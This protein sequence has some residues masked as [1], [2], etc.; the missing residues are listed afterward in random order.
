[1]SIPIPLEK[2]KSGCPDCGLAMREIDPHF[3][4]CDGCSKTAFVSDPAPYVLEVKTREREKSHVCQNC[5]V[6]F[7]SSRYDTKFCSSKCRVAYHRNDRKKPAFLLRDKPFSLEKFYL[8]DHLSPHSGN[9]IANILKHQGIDLGLQVMGGV[10]AGMCAVAPEI[11]RPFQ[12]IS[13]RE[14]DERMYAK[15]EAGQIA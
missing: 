5:D 1:M 4:I 14:F 15:R 2:I 3:Y 10:I 13:Q 8:V 9:M 7:T 12:E 11:A 6:T